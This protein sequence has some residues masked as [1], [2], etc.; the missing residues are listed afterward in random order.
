METAMMIVVVT[1]GLGRNA[2]FAG[3][4]M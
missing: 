4:G 1:R 2:S 3:R